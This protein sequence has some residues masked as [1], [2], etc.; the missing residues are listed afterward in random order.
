MATPPAR[1]NVGSQNQ[2]QPYFIASHANFNRPGGDAAAA[3]IAAGA[4]GHE[5][6]PPVGYRERQ[7]SPMLEHPDWSRSRD[8]IQ[9]RDT[10]PRDDR[11]E[12]QA[13]SSKPSHERH[14]QHSSFVAAPVRSGIP[15]R[16]DIDPHH[17]STHP[18]GVPDT[19]NLHSP[20][21]VPQTA[22]SGSTFG[23]AS[24]SGDEK[25]QQQATTAGLGGIGSPQG[26]A[27]ILTAM[28][29]S[30][31]TAISG[32]GTSHPRPDLTPSE[33]GR[34]VDAGSAAT[35]KH[36]EKTGVMSRSRSKSN[37]SAVASVTT[38]A[39]SAGQANAKAADPPS[40]RSSVEE[41]SME[42]RSL[43][44]TNASPEP[45]ETLDAGAGAGNEGTSRWGALRNVVQAAASIA[46][47]GIS[48]T[49]QRSNSVLHGSASRSGADQSTLF[50]DVPGA[51]P[52]ASSSA[53]STTASTSS[54]PSRPRSARSSESAVTLDLNSPSATNQPM[55]SS[56]KLPF[57]ERYK[58]MADNNKGATSMVRQI[59]RSSSE[60]FGGSGD[61]QSFGDLSGGLNDTQARARVRENTD[62]S[63][64]PWLRT[65]SEIS[66]TEHRLQGPSSKSFSGTSLSSVDST[67]EGK[68]RVVELAII[69]PSASM[70]RLDGNVSSTYDE[71][72]AARARKPSEGNADI[73]GLM[74]DLK[75]D[76]DRFGSPSQEEH[77]YSNRFRLDRE[78]YQSS[79]LAPSDSI[80]TPGFD[81]QRRR[82]AST[83]IN[84]AVPGRKACQKCG[85]ALKG[86]RY[87]KRDGIVLCEADYKEMF[88]P[89]VS[90][91]FDSSRV[92]SPG[93]G[94]Y[95]LL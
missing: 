9:S 58:Q 45:E 2:S 33:Y 16:L 30:L 65:E 21:L 70:N 34:R 90:G 80:S 4:Q 64:L 38:R 56:G 83:K 74:E 39:S 41:R 27:S 46:S 44:I 5:L 47:T 94:S 67:R 75:A 77:E 68:D 92:F 66:A 71:R 89:K 69:T 26:N 60:R 35:V 78:S 81:L 12:Q 43:R 22:T 29:S 61:P 49:I 19:K 55:A 13:T 53:I 76:L 25:S 18:A 36:T 23:L 63:S 31:K 7:A 88:L 87:V 72:G 3:S 15:I 84:Q 73:E 51:F 17:G 32:G 8:K 52:I 10:Y 40:N 50:L 59:S 28:T 54:D 91:S 6:G 14:P 93:N 42:K 1:V 82:S 95:P 86:Q 11:R 37:A 79:L 85:L 24:R 57:F 48:S 62:E 20:V